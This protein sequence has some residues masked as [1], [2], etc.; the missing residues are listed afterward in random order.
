MT[1]AYTAEGGGYVATCERCHWL[2]WH[3]K[4]KDALI[5]GRDH[6]CRKADLDPIGQRYREKARR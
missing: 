6:K 5:A 4:R 3:P 2:A 1:M